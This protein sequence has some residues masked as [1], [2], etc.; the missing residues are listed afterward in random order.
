MSIESPKP[1]PSVLVSAYAVVIIAV[2]AIP[3]EAPAIII[4][5]IAL[6]V[7]FFIILPLYFSCVLNNNMHSRYQY[8]MCNSVII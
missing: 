2:E 5:A 8:I 4:A 3:V 7:N 1:I 6:C